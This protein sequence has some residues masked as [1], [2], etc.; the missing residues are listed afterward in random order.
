MII[1]GLLYLLGL[2]KWLSV[3]GLSDDDQFQGLFNRP[4]KRPPAGV[5]AEGAHL[6]PLRDRHGEFVSIR[7]SRCRRRRYCWRSRPLFTIF[8]NYFPSLFFSTI[9]LPCVDLGRVW[10]RILQAGGEFESL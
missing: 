4:L 3:L 10:Y 2:S 1:S 6:Q 9:F 5:R 7:R 8:V